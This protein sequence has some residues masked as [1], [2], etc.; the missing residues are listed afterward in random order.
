MPV[1]YV[2]ID[3]SARAAYLELYKAEAIATVNARVQAVLSTNYARNAFL[4]LV[5][6]HRAVQAFAYLAD[7]DRDANIARY[8]LIESGIGSYGLTR[9]QVAESYI[10]YNNGVSRDVV[11]LYEDHRHTVLEAIPAQDSKTHIDTLVAAF[12]ARNSIWT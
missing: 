4:E 2:D 12:L 8:P 6:Q 1:V 7:P 3:A 10:G 9:Q 5:Y 11:A